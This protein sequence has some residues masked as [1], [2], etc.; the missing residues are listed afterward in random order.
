MHSFKDKSGRDWNV[1]IT[2]GAVKRVKAELKI[3]L[4]EVLNGTLFERI[5]S[6]PMLVM[7]IVWSIVKPDDSNG[8][9]REA[10]DKQIGGQQITDA[11]K[12]FV[13]ELVDFFQSR[14][15]A[16]A[17]A[18]S[19]VDQETKRAVTAIVSLIESPEMAKKLQ[20]A[21][22]QTLASARGV[23]SGDS[24]ALSG[25]IQTPSPSANST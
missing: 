18:V 24:R 16:L 6:D 14:G 4:M 9:A 13:D 5:G 20:D 21:V 19:R 2:I 22:D 7:D 11:S 23:L 8:T 12:A 25:L 3:D 1:D 17:A 15:P 10:F